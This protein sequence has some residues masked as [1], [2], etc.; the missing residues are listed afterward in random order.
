MGTCEAPDG[1]AVL[2]FLTVPTQVMRASN[3]GWVLRRV[4]WVVVEVERAF[5]RSFE[6]TKSNKTHIITAHS[7]E[8]AS[9]GVGSCGLSA[10]LF[11][12][13]A[14]ERYNLTRDERYKDI[15]ICQISVKIWT[16]GDVFCK[17]SASLCPDKLIKIVKPINIRRWKT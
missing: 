14:A 7:F 10:A 5:Q 13:R 8:L 16:N 4:L 1:K 2:G 11:L 6:K 12:W 9:I 15:K 3:A 17:D